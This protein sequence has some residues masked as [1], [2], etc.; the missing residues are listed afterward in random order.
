M[1]RTAALQDQ[2]ALTIRRLDG[3][4]AA[5]LERLAQRDSAETPAGTVYAAAAPDGSLL[6]AISLET[7]R[8]VADPFVPTSGAAKL[9][10][11]WAR[12][13]GGRARPE[14]ARAGL[15]PAARRAA[16]APAPTGSP[17]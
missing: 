4:D 5:A 2:T 15:W 8:L 12:E 10:R 9:L 16:P 17:C 11:V 7:G 13:V 3:G 6:A 1:F 14:R